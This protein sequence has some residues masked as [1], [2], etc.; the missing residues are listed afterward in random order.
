MLPRA[1]VDFLKLWTG[2]TISEI[3]SRITREG[4]PLT[5][6]LVLGVSPAQMGVLSA[7]GSA[8]V[9][10]VGVGAGMIADR[11]R[12]RPLMIGTDIARA[13][14]LATVP[15]A[16][17]RGALHYWQLVVVSAVAGVLTVQFDVAYQSYLPSL[18]E[19]RDL[20]EG[21]RRLAMSASV[22]EILGPSLTGVLVQLIT[23]PIA[24]LVDAVSFVV[25]AVSVWAIRTPEPEPQP[26]P[27]ESLRE[28]AVEGARVILAHP[29]LR[30][31]ALRS[32]TAFFSM[33]ALF[34][35]YVLYAMR[36]LHLNTAAFGFM[37]ALGGVGSLVG[38]YLSRRALQW[39]GAGQLLLASAVVGAMVNLLV[40]LAAS[41]PRYA[42]LCMC[43]AQLFGDACWSLYFIN[44]TTLRQ[45][46]APEHALGRVNA[47][48][49]LASRGMLPLGAL[50]AGVLADRIGITGTLWA[51]AIGVLLSSL[52]LLPPRRIV[53]PEC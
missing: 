25:S 42:L 34:T 5:A 11:I 13:I 35:L 27:H 22:A 4:L 7:V 9:L 46:I 14:V 45:Q 1:R 28:E 44:E 26:H 48:M 39:M 6:V 41:V 43:A 21:N 51:G 20:L 36:V 29:T 17:A 47:A 12:R 24:I 38:A 52:W 49:Q 18:L 15:L 31:L 2:Q 8:A 37:I 3:C 30:A 53:H 16:A 33:G 23:A 19:K 50:A 10:V 32:I 40:P